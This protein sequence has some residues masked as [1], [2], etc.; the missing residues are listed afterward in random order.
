M[1]IERIRYIDG[2]RAVAVLSVV[3]YHSVQFSPAP[4]QHGIWNLLLRQGC[5]GVELF[6]VLSG[7]CL[8][9]PFLAR[10]YATGSA[11]FSVPGFAARR[12]VRILPPFYAALAVCLAIAAFLSLN[13]RAYPLSTAPGTLAPWQI[14]KQ[15]TFSDLH[16]SYANMSFWSLALEFRWYAFF[17]IALWLWTKSK[18]AFIAVA[19]LAIMSQGTVAGSLD[20]LTLPAFMA[21]IV[22]ADL[23]LRPIRIQRYVWVC[24]AAAG[25]VTLMDTPRTEW[26]FVDP[27]SEAAAFCFVLCCGASPTMRRLLSAKALTFTGTA[28]YSIYL[29]HAPVIAVLEQSGVAPAAAASCGLLAGVAFWWFAERPFVETSLRVRLIRNLDFLYRWLAFVGVPAVLELRDA[30]PRVE[31]VTVEPVT[32]RQT[33]AV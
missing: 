20:L 7:F 21:G 33:I 4:Q 23:Y 31:T 2:L 1:P 13:H 15:L 27:F 10:L 12:L 25:L 18:R 29:V 5:H 11:S 8:S 28:S 6:F 14:I 19:A 16:V 26:G 22:A 3:V 30:R 9:Y 24:F 32:P 17:P